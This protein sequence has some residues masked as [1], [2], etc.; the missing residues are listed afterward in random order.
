MLCVDDDVCL[1]P[2]TL[3]DTI[4]AVRQQPD[5]F[6]A[7]GASL[8]AALPHWIRLMEGKQDSMCSF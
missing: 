6:M 1:H 4:A 5:V 3:R 2:F 8:A 7:T